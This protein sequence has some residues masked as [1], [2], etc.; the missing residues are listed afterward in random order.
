ML[1]GVRQRRY[2]FGIGKIDISTCFYEEPD[3]LRMPRSAV[4]KDDRFQERSPA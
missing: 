2:S 1:A 3:N 4:S